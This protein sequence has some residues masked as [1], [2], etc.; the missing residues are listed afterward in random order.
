[1]RVDSNAIELPNL[2]NNGYQTGRYK[3]LTYIYENQIKQAILVIEG[4]YTIATVVMSAHDSD[5]FDKYLP[6][7]KQMLS[8]VK[9]LGGTVKIKKQ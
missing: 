8:S 4:K 9:L 7:F 1:M 3:L 6:A 2:K 5:E